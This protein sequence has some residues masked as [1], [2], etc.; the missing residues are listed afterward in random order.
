MFFYGFFLHVFMGVLIGAPVS[1]SEMKTFV[2]LCRDDAHVA[3]IRKGVGWLYNSKLTKRQKKNIYF[4][5]SRAYL[6]L[7][8]QKSAAAMMHSLLYLDPCLTQLPTQEEQLNKLF[9][10]TRR[11]IIQK[12]AG[13][14]ILSHIPPSPRELRK[15][16]RIE[17]KVSD[18][19]TTRTLNLYYRLS[20]MDSYRIVPFVRQNQQLYIATFPAKELQG[21]KAF[22]YYIEAANCMKKRAQEGSSNAP[23]TIILESSQNSA[24]SIVGMTLV[25][26]SAALLIGSGI[27]FY[28]LIN[29]SQRWKLT[30]SA[31]QKEMV[32]QRLL[33]YNILAWGGLGLSAT[34]GIIGVWLLLPQKQSSPQKKPSQTAHQTLQRTKFHCLRSVGYSPIAG[35]L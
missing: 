15:K 12:E 4:H 21:A 33:T 10:E 1:S 31:E 25:G 22:Y 18:K 11:H 26:L 32:E 27:S 23:I 7:G 5:V 28:V 2:R 30:H 24:R 3:C 14:P 6:Y 35:D 13:P 17:V 19:F 8:K 9:E 29:E 34:A 20:K 16:H